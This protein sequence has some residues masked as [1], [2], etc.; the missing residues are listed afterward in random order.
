CC[1]LGRRAGGHCGQCRTLGEWPDGGT[2]MKNQL[3]YFQVYLALVAAGVALI[4]LGF[5]VPTLGAAPTMAAFFAL[6]TASLIR[7]AMPFS[8]WLDGALAV[9]GAIALIVS[10]P[11]EG[12]MPVHH[13]LA[14]ISAWAFAWLFVERLS[15]AIR[16]GKLPE[17]GTG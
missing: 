2:G 3:S 9:F 8:L 5:S 11:A 10:L 14:L 16:L 6:A 13:W 1:G 17:T 12:Q 7:F 4:G 15:G